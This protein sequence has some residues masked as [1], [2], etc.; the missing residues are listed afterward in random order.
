VKTN[1][2]AGGLGLGRFLPII[3]RVALPA[4][5]FLTGAAILVVEVIATRLLSP[6]FGSTIYTV[7]S[8]ISVVLAALSCGYAL[9]GKLADKYPRMLMFY[10]IIGL[11]GSLVLII[12]ILNQYLLPEIGYKLSL[13]SG[14]L[15]V[16]MLLFFIPSFTLGML[17]P[18]AVKLQ[19]LKTPDVG[20]GTASGRIFFWSTLGSIC[21]SLAAGFLLIPNFGQNSILLAVGLFLMLLGVLPIMVA[22]RF[23]LGLLLLAVGIIMAIPTASSSQRLLYEHD[24]VYEKLT[25]YDG[26]YRGRPTRFFQQDRSSSGAMFLSGDKNDLV[27]DYTKYY[28]LYKLFQPDVKQALVIGGGVYSIPKALLNDLPEATVDVSEIEPSLVDLAKQYFELPDSPRLNNYVVDGRRLLKQSDKN[29]DYIYSDVYY[30][31][32]SIPSHFTTTE[33]FQTAKDRLNE[34]GIFIANVIGDLARTSNSFSLAEIKTFQQIFPNSYFFGVDTPGGDNDQNIIFVGFKSS[35]IIDMS[36][37][38][39]TSSNDEI[40]RNLASKQID[41]KR[42]ELSD[43]LVITDDY[44]PVDLMTAAM[45]ERS[46]KPKVFGLDGERMMNLIAQQLRYGSRSLSAPGHAAVQ[47]FIESELKAY[48]PVVSRLGYDHT[49]VTADYK[50]TNIIGRYQPNNPRRILIGTHYDS[51]RLA[52]LDPTN[53]GAY[54]PGANDSASGVAMLL[55]LARF[56][57][58][59]PSKLNI[60]IDLVFFDGEEGEEHLTNDYSSWQ[61]LGSNFLANNLK[62]LYPAKLPESGVVLDMICDKNLNLLQETN[63]ITYAKDN[64]NRFWEIGKRRDSKAF[65]ANTNR[66]TAIMDDHMPLNNAGIPTFLVIDYDYPYFHTTADTLDKCSSTSLQTVGNTLLE[67][68][69]TIPPK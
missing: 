59:N 1:K 66:S 20:V 2:N 47:D 33:F 30:S 43:Q 34:G 50:I 3:G 38:R 58:L 18:Y 26:E 19:T 17:S 25:I 5:V 6:Y 56:I 21:G 35:E 45:L 61:P 13:V 12:R 57:G 53:P 54:M 51:K 64:F 44:A 28:S 10:G 52:S 46:L 16:S 55:E 48:L 14:P 49:G 15:L 39:V 60:G 62:K 63:S 22:K 69:A 40:I 32:Y 11:S 4:T 67:Y 41:P 9:G 24:G 36:S 37:T 7:S 42:F 68:I 29:Y 31:L 8:V 65:A 27:Y 23:R